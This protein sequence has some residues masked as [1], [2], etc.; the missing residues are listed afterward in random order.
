[1]FLFKDNSNKIAIRIAEIDDLQRVWDIEH[2]NFSD[3]WTMPEFISS[4]LEHDFF[5]LDNL[6]LNILIGYA[7]GF[8]ATDEYNIIN[9]SIAKSHQRKGYGKF[10]MNSLIEYNNNYNYFYLEVRK[11]NKQAISFYEKFNFKFCYIRKNYYDSPQDDAY[12]MKFENV[13]NKDSK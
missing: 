12:I 3:P 7:I 8:G 13:M 11:N 1:M 6:L 9:F 10:L 5:V 4:F 2:K